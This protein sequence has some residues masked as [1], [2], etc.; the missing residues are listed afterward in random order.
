MTNK[1]N[2][3]KI[4]CPF[5]RQEWT[6]KMI[7]ELEYIN[8]GCPTCGYGEYAD[9]VIKIICEHCGRVVYSKEITIK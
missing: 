3:L 2:E 9:V 5:C 8:A 1:N 6:A 4:L 7:G